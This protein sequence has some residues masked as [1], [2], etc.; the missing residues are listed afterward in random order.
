MVQHLC[1][2]S[3]SPEMNWKVVETMSCV[4]FLWI[5]FF[6]KIYQVIKIGMVAEWNGV[7]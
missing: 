7:I 3:S 5:Y 4:N 6:D 1:V 2:K